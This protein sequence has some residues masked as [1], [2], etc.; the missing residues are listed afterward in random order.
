MFQKENLHHAN[1]IEGHKDAILEK[2]HNF[3]DK[4]LHFNI[5]NNSDYWFKEFDSIG[6]DDAR[7]I[8]GMQQKRAAMGNKKLFVI[9]FNS[10]TRE[11]QNALLKVFEEPTE[12]TYFF[13][14]THSTSS[15]LPTLKSRMSHSIIYSNSNEKISKMAQKFLKGNPAE[16]IKCIKKIIDSETSKA[17]ALLMLSEIEKCVHELI[18]D[19]KLEFTQVEELYKVKSYL[20]DTSASVKMLLEHLSL[21]LPK[22]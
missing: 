18:L 19:K 7:L 22:I 17:E 4:E 20:N 8:S 11:A 21:V 3:F 13:L 14:I 16:R 1:L 10:I 9:A 15:L 2:L 12:D 6:V 5:H